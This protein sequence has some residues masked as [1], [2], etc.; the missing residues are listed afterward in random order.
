M[1]AKT[2]TDTT[3]STD[4][5]MTVA[6]RAAQDAHDSLGTLAEGARD[7]RQRV[8]P[9]L[10]RA[11][12]EAATLARRGMDAVR[13]GSHQLRDKARHATDTTTSYIRDEPVKSMLIAAAVGAALMAL[14]G[15]LSR[16]HHHD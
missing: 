3:L 8:A 5:N 10:S 14:V 4:P 13:E 15:L 12:E 1:Y 7:A 11:T 2:P 16:R 6:T 9:L